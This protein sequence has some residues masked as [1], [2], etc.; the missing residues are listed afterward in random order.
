VFDVGTCKVAM[1]VLDLDVVRLG[2]RNNLYRMDS[3]LEEY[4]ALC[5]TQVSVLTMKYCCSM[6]LLTLRS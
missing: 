2:K 4:S 6:T 1:R 5:R 3:T